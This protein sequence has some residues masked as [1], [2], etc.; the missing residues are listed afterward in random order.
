MTEDTFMCSFQAHAMEIATL[1]Y[2]GTIDRIAMHVLKHGEQHEQNSN[3][4]VGLI[5]FKQFFLCVFTCNFPEPND[6]NHIHIL[7]QKSY[8][9]W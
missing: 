9:K 8:S 4:A 1:V 6:H 5:C 3:G 2:E 7:I